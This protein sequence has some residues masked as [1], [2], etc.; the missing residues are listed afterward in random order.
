[1]PSSHGRQ[2]QPESGYAGPGMQ[3]STSDAPRLSSGSPGTRSLQVAPKPK[4]KI[5]RGFTCSNCRARKV[6]ETSRYA[7]GL[8]E[9]DPV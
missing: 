3:G 1:M 6:R 2:R 9:A 4:R 5:N 7:A 8:I